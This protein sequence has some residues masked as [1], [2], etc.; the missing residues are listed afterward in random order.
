VCLLVRFGPKGLVGK[1]VVDI[2]SGTGLTGI[3]A[4]VLG[5]NVIELLTMM[6]G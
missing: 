6:L 4:A 2:G 1:R 3:A 5:A